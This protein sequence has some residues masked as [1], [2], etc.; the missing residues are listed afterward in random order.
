LNDLAQI[1]HLVSVLYGQEKERNLS[2]LHSMRKSN[3]YFKPGNSISLPKIFN[4]LRE[5]SF[6]SK[7]DIREDSFHE[8]LTDQM[9]QGIQISPRLK[10]KALG[11]QETSS[12]ESDDEIFLQMHK[13]K[14]VIPIFD[15]R[16]TDIKDVTEPPLD[17]HRNIIEIFELLVE[18]ANVQMLVF[19]TIILEK[20]I[21]LTNFSLELYFHSYLEQLHR[22][23]LYPQATKITHHT[24]IDSIK[25]INQ[26]HTLL[27]TSCGCGGAWNQNRKCDQCGGSVCGLCHKL[28]KGLFQWCQWCGHGGHFECLDQ[29]FEGNQ[30]CPTGCGHICSL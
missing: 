16:P 29:W 11:E 18:E 17:S 27:Q 20:T 28:V 4:F 12:D 22:F 24:N 5:E 14:E 30:A 6:F 15:I 1:W 21:D 10:N 9:L 7:P 23:K 2:E 8:Q 3:Y 19:L 13:P 26:E 25:E